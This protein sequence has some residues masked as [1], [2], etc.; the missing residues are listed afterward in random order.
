LSMIEELPLPYR[1]AVEQSPWYST[2]HD[3]AFYAV[4]PQLAITGVPWA[5]TGRLHAVLLLDGQVS[6]FGSLER[7]GNFAVGDTTSTELE[8]AG[9]AVAEVVRG[10]YVKTCDV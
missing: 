2:T 8:H 7:G 4:D 3:I 1:R 6:E 5:D 10:D 9:V